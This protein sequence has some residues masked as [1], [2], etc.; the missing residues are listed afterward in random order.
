MLR[1]SSGQRA[2]APP[3]QKSQLPVI[4]GSFMTG[5][6]AMTLVGV[7]APALASAAAPDLRA[8]HEE[9]T[10]SFQHSPVAFTEISE[11][12]RQEIDARLAAAER[13]LTEAHA[14]TDEALARLD[15]LSGK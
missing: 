5:V 9:R 4:I 10:E 8:V 7:V 1:Q 2:E 15:H 6:A 14:Q 13:A 3:A 11:E 12:Q